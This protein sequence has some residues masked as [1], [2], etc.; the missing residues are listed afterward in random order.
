MFKSV[1]QT[2]KMSQ[3]YNILLGEP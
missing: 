3:A 1:A 2:G